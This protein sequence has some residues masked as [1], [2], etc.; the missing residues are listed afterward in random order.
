M[1][2][3]NESARNAGHKRLAHPIK[4]LYNKV[5]RIPGRTFTVCSS[6]MAWQPSYWRYAGYSS[7]KP[8]VKTRI[9]IE[10]LQRQYMT[11]IWTRY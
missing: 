11:K 5:F 8:S 9:Q 2:G 7:D 10:Q 6:Y 1:I 4:A 3:Y